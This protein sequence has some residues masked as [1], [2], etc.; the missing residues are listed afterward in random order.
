MKSEIQEITLAINKF[1]DDRDW[2]Q[3]HD[4]KNL[5]IS[6]NI[7][8]SELLEAFLWKSPEDA[9]IDAIKNELAD[10]FYNAFL[11]ADSYGL[12]VREIV[13]DKLKANDLKYP[14]EKVRGSNKKYNEI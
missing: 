9:N 1:R 11:I 13:L 3:F 14:I 12:N 5:A 7:E 2:R 6:L 8:S 10:V 4:P